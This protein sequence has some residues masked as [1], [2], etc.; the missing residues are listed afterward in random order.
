MEEEKK[1]KIQEIKG[2]FDKTQRER[3]ASAKKVKKRQW[4]NEKGLVVHPS[5]KKRRVEESLNIFGTSRD[6]GG[7]QRFG[8]KKN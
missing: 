5:N 8:R 1:S 7:M 3:W 4:D 6:G 2:A